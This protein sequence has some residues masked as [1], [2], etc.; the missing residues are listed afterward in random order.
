MIRT[1]DGRP[2][3][4]TSILE[5]MVMG[6]RTATTLPPQGEHDLRQRWAH[7]R[8][9]YELNSHVFEDELDAMTALGL[10]VGDRVT[11]TTGLARARR[12]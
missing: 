11:R 2:A 10:V 8:H 7:A 1:A 4:A 6:A 12:R 9:L 5:G 3:G